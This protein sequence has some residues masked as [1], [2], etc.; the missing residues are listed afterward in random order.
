VKSYPLEQL[1]KEVAFIAYYFHWQHDS[2]MQMPHGERRKWCE[3]ISSINRDLS[4]EKG[5]KELK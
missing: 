2:I 5:G 4:N 1:Y 3:Q